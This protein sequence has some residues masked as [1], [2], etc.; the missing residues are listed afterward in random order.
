VEEEFEAL[1][2][3]KQVRVSEVPGDQEP[4]KALP[5]LGGVE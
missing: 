5:G 4:L 1:C 2:P 3:A